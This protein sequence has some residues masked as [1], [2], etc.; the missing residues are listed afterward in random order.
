MRNEENKIPVNKTFAAWAE[1]Y[2]KD[3]KD[4]FTSETEA[5][6]NLRKIPFFRYCNDYWMREN[7]KMWCEE[8]DYILNPP[9]SLTKNGRCCDVLNLRNGNMLVI[10][11]L[12]P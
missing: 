8:K 6:R 10:K 1:E 7:L 3:R 4:Q 12:Q 11:T 2:F 5:L 9:E